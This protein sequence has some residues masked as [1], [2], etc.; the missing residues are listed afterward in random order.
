M[1]ATHGL[2]LHQLV[3][4]MNVYDIS[5]RITSLLIEGFSVIGHYHGGTL[6]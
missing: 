2:G 3:G 5:L 6:F 4:A 1:G